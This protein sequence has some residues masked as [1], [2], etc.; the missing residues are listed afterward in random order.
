MLDYNNKTTSLLT[1]KS[2][3]LLRVRIWHTE[4]KLMIEGLYQ[5]QVRTVSYFRRLE[6]TLFVDLKVAYIGNDKSKPS[7]RIEPILRL[8]SISHTDHTTPQIYY[9][10][11]VINIMT[12][13]LTRIFFSPLI[14][15]S[16]VIYNIQP[17]EGDLDRSRFVVL[18]RML[19]T[20]KLHA[21][22]CS[23]RTSPP[24]ENYLLFYARFGKFPGSI[25]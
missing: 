9:T 5:N 21:Y 25:V 13:T 11:G 23:F 22:T 7:I 6:S 14:T 1:T 12:F 2:Q 16:D 24:M 20:K 18:I 19:C 15:I 3:L 10:Y 4:L 17:N 8:F